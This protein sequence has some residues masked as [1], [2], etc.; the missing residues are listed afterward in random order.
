MVESI[1]DPLMPLDC[2]EPVDRLPLRADVVALLRRAGVEFFRIPIAPEGEAMMAYFLSPAYIH[3]HFTPAWVAE[4]GSALTLLRTFLAKVHPEDREHMA[5]VADT[6]LR[7]DGYSTDITSNRFRGVSDLGQW[8]WYEV[9]MSVRQE[10]ELR[11]CEGLIINVAEQEEARRQ[12]ARLA[13]E[14]RLTGMGN[15]AASVHSLQRLIQPLATNPAGQASATGAGGLAA[16]GAGSTELLPS[17]GDAAIA[18][19]ESFAIIWLDLSGFGRINTLMGRAQGDQLLL[20][21]ARILREWIQDGDL[22]TRPNSDEFLIVLPGRD[23]E[24][25]LAAARHLQLLL[26]RRLQELSDLKRGL[27]FRA[28]I[29]AYPEH[30]HDAET[31]LGYAAA[32]LDQASRR[33]SDALVVYHHRLTEAAREALTLEQALQ[34]ALTG[35]Q[36][37]LVF[38]PQVGSEGE[39]LG[40]EALLR[41][42]SPEL[43][44]ISP[45]RFIPLAEATGQ[46]HALGAWVIE[47]ACRHQ[48]QWRQQGLTIAP[49]GINISA[50][51]LTSDRISVA[52]HLLRSLGRHRLE[53]SALH[54]E[55]TESGALEESGVR[56]LL[57]IHAAG[58]ALE[59]DDFGTGFASLSSL[60]RLPIHTLKLDQSFVRQLDSSEASEAIL[61]ASHALA[62]SIGA[63]ALVEGVEEPWQ[64]ERLLAMGFR[65]FQG[66]LFS[67]PLEAEAYAELLRDPAALARRQRERSGPAAAA[68]PGGPPPG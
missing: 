4:Q 20:T 16:A 18:A 7:S 59:I 45:G 6:L 66:H 64:A 25:A 8:C 22:V 41:W 10:G 9:R 28:G 15:M 65:C 30:G 67:R 34:Q 48:A 61:R 38:Q 40:C 55:I 51:Q 12:L 23:S 11:I 19:G 3:C 35:D 1:G 60:L 54:V 42:Q 46:I 29:C 53:P 33:G 39:L 13:F 49:M 63:T 14:D 58:L 27:S 31:L 37:R 43:G 56:Q 57:A 26:P 50:V 24:A 5:A 17:G 68:G 52:E 21:T 62:G 2:L 32:A 36:L 44:A 47:A